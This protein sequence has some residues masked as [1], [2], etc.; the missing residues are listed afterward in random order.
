MKSSL[1]SQAH[2]FVNTSVNR[3]HYANNNF[4]ST[5]NDLRPMELLAEKEKNE[6]YNFGQMIKQKYA[7]DFIQTTIKEADNNEK[8]NHW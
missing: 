5:L 6:Y 1:H 4:E 2:F 8:R 7:A 3:F